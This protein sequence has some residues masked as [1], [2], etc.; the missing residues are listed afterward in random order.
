M[1]DI[2]LIRTNPELVKENIKK[3]HFSGTVRSKKKKDGRKTIFFSN[4][5]FEEELLLQEFIYSS[6]SAA[7]L[8]HSENDSGGAEHDVTTGVD[9]LHEGLVGGCIFE[10]DMA[11]LVDGEFRRGVADK[12]VRT[13]TDS[14]EHGVAFDFEACAFD[15]CRK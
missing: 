12:R 14:N 6:C 2:N 8:S 3:G 13:V 4:P 10:K 9:L 15:I 7:P 11:L 5:R 1:I